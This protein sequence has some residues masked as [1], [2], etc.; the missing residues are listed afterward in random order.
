MWWYPHGPHIQEGLS[1]AVDLLAGKSLA[2]RI[3]GALKVA[4]LYLSRLHRQ[5]E[6]KRPAPGVP[7]RAGTISLESSSRQ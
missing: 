1:G 4:G 7:G 3:K 5:V 6:T 2:K